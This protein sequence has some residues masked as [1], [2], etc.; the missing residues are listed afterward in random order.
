MALE[1]RNGSGEYGH[2][3]A[4]PWPVDPD[5][6]EGHVCEC[7][8]RWVY[9]P[10]RWDPVWTLEELQRQQQ[11]GA[12]LQGIIPRFRPN[13]P[14]SL[15]ADATIVPLPPRDTPAPSGDSGSGHLGPEQPRE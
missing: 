1:M 11:A 9:Q 5:I 13:L 14:P 4:L 3:C 6:P 2:S 7:G 8:R 15:T 12:F 10:A